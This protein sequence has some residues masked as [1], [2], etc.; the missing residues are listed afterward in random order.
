V[1]ALDVGPFGLGGL[2]LGR[3]GVDAAG[4]EAE[5]QQDG[6]GQGGETLD[7][8]HGRG[9]PRRAALFGTADSTPN[10]ARRKRKTPSPGPGTAR[11]GR[12]APARSPAPAPT[13]APPAARSR[14]NDSPPAHRP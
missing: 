1:L 2:F 6:G 13:A 10:A 7:D 8:G 9:S 12:S 3:D 14:R 4:G 5:R 11:P